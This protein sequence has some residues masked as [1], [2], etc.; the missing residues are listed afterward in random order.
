MENK[1]NHSSA[2][3]KAL[4]IQTRAKS[5]KNSK[6]QPDTERYPQGAPKLKTI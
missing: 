5:V 1:K 3:I 6:K 4:M 2:T